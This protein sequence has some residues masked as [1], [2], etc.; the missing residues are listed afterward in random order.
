MTFGNRD[1]KNIDENVKTTLLHA[2]ASLCALSIWV[3]TSIKL[4]TPFEDFPP[5]Y[6]TD[7]ASLKKGSSLQIAFISVPYVYVEK[8]AV[9]VTAVTVIVVFRVWKSKSFGSLGSNELHW[10]D[11]SSLSVFDDNKSTE[12]SRQSLAKI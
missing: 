12:I 11:K 5:Y 1:D 7:F 6:K 10:A 4:I 3:L 9:K 8:V 2:L